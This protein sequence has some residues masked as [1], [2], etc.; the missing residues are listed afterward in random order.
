MVYGWAANSLKP[1]HLPSHLLEHNFTS[2]IISVMVL[3]LSNYCKTYTFSLQFAN[4]SKGQN[5]T[6]VKICL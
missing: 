1:T 3:T 5:K 4:R 2:V 6:V